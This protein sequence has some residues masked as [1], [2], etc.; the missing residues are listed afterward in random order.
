VRDDGLDDRISSTCERTLFR[1]YHQKPHFMGRRQDPPRFKRAPAGIALNLDLL[2]IATIKSRACLPPSC[3]LSGNKKENPRATR[4]GTGAAAVFRGA[5]RVARFPTPSSV[6]TA[7]SI[8]FGAWRR[9]SFKPG[10][11][12]TQGIEMRKRRLS[13][14]QKDSNRKPRTDL[15][16]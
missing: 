12:G 14:E 2:P 16:G 1:V 7:E 3:L 8:T 15:A 11:D 10:E 13:V 9:G 4:A 6:Q 5:A